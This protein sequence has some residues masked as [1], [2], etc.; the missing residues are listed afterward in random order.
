MALYVPC[1]L[2]VKANSNKLMLIYL[3]YSFIN[4]TFI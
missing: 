4:L 3:A 2:L 1:F